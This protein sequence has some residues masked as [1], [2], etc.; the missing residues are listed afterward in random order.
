MQKTGRFLIAIAAALL[1]AQAVVTVVPAASERYTADV[2]LSPFLTR[3][4]DAVFQNGC[5]RE[6]QE[7]AEAEAQGRE[8]QDQE[9]V[10]NQSY[11]NAF[12]SANRFGPPPSRYC[13]FGDRFNED[14]IRDR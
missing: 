1:S 6:R 10:N 2:N 8:I 13:F 12:T 7:E 14:I 9:V 5:L 4:P 3:G 11:R